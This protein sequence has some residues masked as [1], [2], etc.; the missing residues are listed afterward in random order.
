MTNTT[1]A[2]HKVVTDNIHLSPKMIDGTKGV[3]P[4]YCPSLE[5]KIMRFAG[6]YGLCY[7]ILIV[8][9]LIKFG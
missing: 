4:R 3:G 6:R 9:D 7:V 2:T 8:E 1:E 5:A